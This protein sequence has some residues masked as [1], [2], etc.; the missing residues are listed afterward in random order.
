MNILYILIICIIIYVIYSSNK[1][2][3]TSGFYGYEC[4]TCQGKNIGQCLKCNQCGIYHD[5][6]TYKCIKGD[7]DGPYDTN[8]K[9]NFWLH[10]DQF[11]RYVYENKYLIEVP[12][13]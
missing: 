7:K 11:S 10:N 6:N 13:K 9:T 2:T 1:E 12:Y 8:I 3:F 4:K 5:G